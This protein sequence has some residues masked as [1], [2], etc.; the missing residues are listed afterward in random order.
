MLTLPGFWTGMFIFS[1]PPSSQAFRP[2]LE[3]WNP[4]HGLPLV[5]RPPNYSTWVAYT[6]LG[7]SLQTADSGSSQTAQSRES[8]PYHLSLSYSIGSVSL[9]QYC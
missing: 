6:F 4:H 7:L 8:I 5:L 3:P 2:R 1:F 9:N